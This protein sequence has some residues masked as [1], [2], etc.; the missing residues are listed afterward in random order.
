MARRAH[1]APRAAS[2]YQRVLGHP[3]VAGVAFS[4]GAPDRAGVRGLA[5][6][7]RP[8]LLPSLCAFYL[9][10]PARRWPC[11]SCTMAPVRFV[12]L[13]LLLACCSPRP[14][15][16][17]SSVEAELY[18]KPEPEPAARRRPVHVSVET[19]AP[20]PEDPSL[21]PEPSRTEADLE[22]EIRKAEGNAEH[23]RRVEKARRQNEL[24]KLR[25]LR[26]AERVYELQLCRWDEARALPECDEL[27]D[28][29]VESAEGDEKEQRKLRALDEK[30]K[31][32]RPPKPVP[33]PEPKVYSCADGWLSGC[34]CP[35][36]RSGCCS[37]HGG[38]VGCR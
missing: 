1:P 20:V 30:W 6:C 31:R 36:P 33:P 15:R 21:D 10:L 17:A 26:P 12:A 2:S 16:S 4:V 25:S 8:R 14:E 13:A 9:P 32:V 7:R 24:F 5:E 22:R 11:S 34:P 37:H 27:A 19:P 35:G 29:L 3:G 28:L 18:S 23:R 38:I